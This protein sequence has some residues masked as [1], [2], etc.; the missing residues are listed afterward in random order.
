MR[1]AAA[2]VYF[3]SGIGGAVPIYQ[4]SPAL[5]ALYQNFK[6][7]RLGSVRKAAADRKR[8]S[9]STRTGIPTLIRASGHSS[10]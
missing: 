5:T 2:R 10:R 4:G 9:T 3:L 1:E 7:D 6:P 8:V